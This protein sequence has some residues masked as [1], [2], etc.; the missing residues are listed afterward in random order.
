MSEGYA[1]QHVR[2][3]EAAGDD[4]PTGTMLTGALLPARAVNCGAA[5]AA[6]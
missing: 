3:L 6:A 5:T 2:L 1:A 4:P